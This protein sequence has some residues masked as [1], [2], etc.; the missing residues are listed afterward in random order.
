MAEAGKE[1]YAVFDSED[2]SL[3][4]FVDDEGKYT[5]GEIIGTKTY[6]TGIEERHYGENAIPW[7]DYR[8]SI[9]SVNFNNR[10]S[11]I[12]LAYWFNLCRNL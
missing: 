7:A 8:L 5:D 6:W 12:S 1:A 11:P 4:F 10:I 2:G 9:L 3:T